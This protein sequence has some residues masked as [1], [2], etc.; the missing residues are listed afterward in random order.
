[1]VQ[2]KMT[3][4]ID[5]GVNGVKRTVQ[6]A[7]DNVQDLGNKVQ[8][9]NHRVH[10]VDDKLDQVERSSSRHPLFLIP[11]IHTSLQGP[12]SERAFHGGFCPQIHPPIITLHARL[13]TVV[14]L[15]GFFT[16][17]YLIIGNPLAPSCGY[18]ENVRYSQLSLASIPDCLK[19]VAGA[20]KSILWFA[21]PRRQPL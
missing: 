6:D 13:I 18:T 12:S 4:S 17:V 5:D 11:S 14:Q 1:M 10:G 9:V 3:Q 20:G 15:S 19:F 7:R 21:L 8:D 2:M 16:E